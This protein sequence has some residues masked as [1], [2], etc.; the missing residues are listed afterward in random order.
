M[1]IKQLAGGA[2]WKKKERKYFT[3]LTIIAFSNRN[4]SIPISKRND[5]FICHNFDGFYLSMSDAKLIHSQVSYKQTVIE[6]C[7]S[8]FVFFLRGAWTYV[9]SCI[10]IYGEFIIGN[11]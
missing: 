8:Y 5:L 6:H 7:Q 2:Q 10:M 4:Y 9:T 11:L 3:Q 1:I